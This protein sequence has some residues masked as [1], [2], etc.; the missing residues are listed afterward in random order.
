MRKLRPL[1]LLI[2]LGLSGAAWAQEQPMPPRATPRPEAQRPSPPK[3]AQAKPAPAKP[4]LPTEPKARLE[5]L[6][7]RLHEAQSPAEARQTE[8]EIERMLERSGSATA[9][10]TFTR[11]GQAFAGR[12]FDT[13]LDLLDYTLALRPHFA[14]GYHRRAQ[15]HLMRKDEEAALRDL[16]I[17]LA[18]EPRHFMALATF[19]GLMRAS[20][21]RKGAYKALTRLKDLN[22]HFPDIGEVLEKLRPEIEGQ[23]I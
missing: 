1:L 5:A 4:A 21:D 16:R 9:D 15:V 13:A 20:G 6:F 19:A 12:D 8:K 7:G 11:A 23:K 18:L 10:L 22:P 17:T 3:A 2:P 14:E